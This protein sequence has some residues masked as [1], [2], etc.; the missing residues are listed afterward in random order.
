[1]STHRLS[2]DLHEFQRR[3]SETGFSLG[4][5]V[6]SI[7]DRGYGL[8]LVIFTLPIAMPMPAPGIATPFGAVMLLLALQVMIRRK[9]PWLPRWALNFRVSADTG[10]K[11]LGFGIWFF[12]R[13]ERFIRPRQDWVFN[14]VGHIMISI[15]LFAMGFL[16]LLP[17]PLTNSI[18]AGVI[19][20]LGIGLVEKDGIFICAGLA[21]GLVIMLLYIIAFWAIVHFGLQG[22]GEAID[23]LRAWLGM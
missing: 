16:M 12:A 3:I 2:S 13:L 9:T 21:Y 23:M 1:M 10:R 20:L 22:I 17:I 5:I 11:M 19:L 6:A 8:L 14:G 7:G 15:V 4:E 18:P